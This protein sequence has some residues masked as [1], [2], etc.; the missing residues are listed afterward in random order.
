MSIAFITNC[1]WSLRRRVPKLY[2]GIRA[3]YKI[4]LCEDISE[5][6]SVKLNIVCAK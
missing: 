5:L 1:T 3:T 2:Y 6:N 4:Q